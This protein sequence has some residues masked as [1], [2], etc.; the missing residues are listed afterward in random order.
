[1]RPEIVA[2]EREACHRVSL[3][4]ISRAVERLLVLVAQAKTS[5]GEIEVTHQ[6]RVIARLVSVGRAPARRRTTA[7][8]STLDQVA[9]EIGASWPNGPPATAAVREDR[10]DLGL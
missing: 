4:A 2:L 7:A 10:R 5:G 8:W 6:G 3:P 9:R 1:L